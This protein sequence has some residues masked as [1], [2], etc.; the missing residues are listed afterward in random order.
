MRSFSGTHRREGRSFHEMKK[1][2]HFHFIKSTCVILSFIGIFFHSSPLPIEQHSAISTPLRIK[3]QQEHSICQMVSKAILDRF[4]GNIAVLLL[5]RDTEELLIP[6]QY[7]APRSDEG[8]GYIICKHRNGVKISKAES[9]TEK[10][11]E[12]ALQLLQELQDRQTTIF[13]E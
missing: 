4:E 12:K 9:Y 6:Q 2:L 5:E 11:R 3:A 1:S 13:T 10:Q 7:L 8:D